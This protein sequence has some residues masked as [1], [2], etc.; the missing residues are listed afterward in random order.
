L[1]SWARL[2]AHYKS[3]HL[4]GPLMLRYL[5]ILG[6][7]GFPAFYLLR[8]SKST[9]I[10]DDWPFRVVDA[11]LCLVLFFRDKW[12]ERLKPYY[13]AYSYVVLIVTLP[14]TFVFTS[15]KNDGGTVAVGN[16]LMAVFLVILLTDWR[17]MIVML[18]TGFAA[19]VALYVLTDPN[20]QVPMDYVLRVPILLAVLVAGSLFK[21]A[22]ERATADKVRN[23]YASLAGSI[24]HEMRN[25]LGQLKHSL[26]SMQR[27]L[28][29]PTTMARSHTLDAAAVDALYSYLAQSEVA[30]RRGL[31]VIDM[32]LDE[33]SAKP[34]DTDGFSHLLAGEATRKA[35][36][37]YAFE[38]E[39]DR[40]KVSV[41]VVGDF[42]FRGD[43]TAYL[44]V[45]FNLIKNALYYLVLD[46]AA[47]VTITV[48]QNQVR[49]HDTGPGVPPEL[50]ARLFE[51]FNTVGK[52]G[53]TGLG[54]A[55][56]R[57]VMHAFGGEVHCESVLREYTQF[58]L[59]FPPV[60][61]RESEAHRQ[62]VLDNARAAFAGRRLLV[63]DDD[64]A[65]RMISRHKL[66]PLGAEVDQAAD[67]QSAL[68]ALGKRHYD[69]VLL[70]L[71]MPVLD[72]YAVA[73]KIR[74]GMPGVNRDVRIVAYTSEPAHLAAV[75][76]HKAGMDGFVSK[77]CAQLPLLE[78][79][80]RAMAQPA[81]QA[82][83]DGVLAGR[84]FML[85]DDN[86]HNRKAVAAFL[87]HAGAEVGEAGNGAA[88][89]E[90]LRSTGPWDAVLMDI[91]MP[92]MDG[93]EA[94]QAIRSSP[95][96]WCNLPI[97]ALTA[98][99]DE[100]TVQAAQAAGMNE[101]ITK[102]V[103]AAVLYAKL[104]QLA[105]QATGLGSPLHPTP[106][107]LAEDTGDELLNLQRLES[108]RRIGM[109]EELLQ[110]YIPELARL[111]QR[112]EQ[113]VGQGDLQA[114]MDTLHSL[115]GMSGEAGA[116]ALYQ[117]VR[118]VYVPMAETRGW[119][120]GDTWVDRIK[121]LAA[122]TEQALGRYGPA[123]PTV[124]AD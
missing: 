61:A 123:Q 111:V 107:A 69:L 21:F 108:Y 34:M 17:N 37:E 46:P 104:G 22:A 47:R 106:S 27:A 25:P 64:A 103:D 96:T 100:L 79:L 30:V 114:S 7:V 57:R 65:Q 113:A 12:P 75:K 44:F 117:A 77:P 32:T 92:G 48:G 53:G 29:A 60:S 50:L 74:R 36:R 28:P 58:T 86:P 73:E 4:H 33:V 49:V 15:L 118:A 87:K 18:I 20:P 55:Y 2:F 45:L 31:Q 11:V 98:H 68:D 124:S 80:H 122:Q 62:A 24:A 102:P 120:A 89:L 51:P 119:P 14:L 52:S 76:T 105:G 67:G 1:K 95:A 41:E 19:A 121:M 5:S 101:F 93:F 23:A 99:A 8:F 10:Y 81:H 6:F 40:S 38:S 59:T 83:A 84:R 110:D 26:E 9:P 35:V 116:P 85:V 70:D 39:D 54:L 109:L 78:A 94:A 90:Q 42:V 63:V 115:L 112:L 43:E 56:C 16:T 13:F 72:G 66:Q 88:A 82:S 71:N 3:H 97:V 91:N